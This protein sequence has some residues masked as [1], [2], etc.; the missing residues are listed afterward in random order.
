MKHTHWVIAF[1]LIALLGVMAGCNPEAKNLRKTQEYLFKHPEFSS[2]Y[3]SEQFPDKPDSVIVKTDTLIE[4]ATMDSLVYD[5]LTVLHDTTLIRTIVKTQKIY[6][7]KDSIIYRENRAE[8]ERLQLGL[9]ACQTNNG[10]TLAKNTKL[11]QDLA[12]WK[13]K[14]KTRWLWIAL[15]IGGAATVAIFKVIKAVRP[16]V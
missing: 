5:T 16:S 1:I 14:A 4:I 11:E 6:I 7:R 12:G 2:G 10:I 13:K 9:L 3:C 15:L 8:Q